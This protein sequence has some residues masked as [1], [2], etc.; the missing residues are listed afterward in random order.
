MQDQQSFFYFILKRAAS[1][2]AEILKPQ[3]AELLKTTQSICTDQAELMAMPPMI[4]FQN[5]TT[6]MTIRQ[7]IAHIAEMVLERVSWEKDTF[8]TELIDIAD[9]CKVCWDSRFKDLAK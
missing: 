7:M 9:K 5:C 2:S 8:W 3:V 4:T 1:K 6:V